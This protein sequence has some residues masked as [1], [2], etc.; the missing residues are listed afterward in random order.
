MLAR[1]MVYCMSNF[2]IGKSS[3]KGEITFPTG[4]TSDYTRAKTKYRDMQEK[5]SQS[6]FVNSPVAL[7]QE[8]TMLTELLAL[9][10]KELLHTEIKW[11]EPRLAE[12]KTQLTSTKIDFIANAY[13]MPI[14]KKGD[15]TASIQSAQTPEKNLLDLLETCKTQDGL[16]DPNA[17]KLL[18]ALKGK[19][20]N[21]AHISKVLEMSRGDD[22]LVY[23]QMANAVEIMADSGMKPSRIVEQLSEISAYEYDAGEVVVDFDKLDEAVT[24]MK[25]GVDDVDAF[26]FA[27]YLK[28]DFADKDTVR[29]SFLNLNKKDIEYKHSIGILN[30]LSVRDVDT[31]KININKDAVNAVALLKHSMASSR[32]NETKERRNPIALLGVQTFSMGNEHSFVMKDGKVISRMSLSEESPEDLK[33]KY[34]AL[35]VSIE[36]D[37]CLE[38]A[39]KYKDENGQIDRKYL[40]VA[41]FLRQQ[42][43]MVYNALFKQLD[44]AIKEDG[45]INE[46][47]LNAVK[48]LRTA[49]ALCDDVD[50]LLDTCRKDEQGNYNKDDIKDVCDLT[51]YIIGGKEVCSLAP[52]IRGNED[53]RDIVFTCA[54]CFVSPKKILDVI[55]MLKT[56]EGQYGENEVEM[57]GNLAEVFFSDTTNYGDESNFL[58]IA[59]EIMT[60]SRGKDGKITDDAGGICAIMKHANEPIES[61][62]MA[63]M[64]CRNSENLVDEKLAQILWDMYV[65][66]SNL[67]EVI[68]MINVCKPSFDTIDYA[69]ADM[70]ISLLAAKFPKEQIASLVKH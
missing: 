26:N 44:A 42:A 60:I 64:V 2:S 69:K 38:F 10:K 14:V 50:S 3:Q 57:F 37:M 54:E 18:L 51:S 36:D 48:E 41:H 53:V 62:K 55:P 34:D 46:D 11:I 45:T 56:P 32:D 61:I 29:T 59:N 6:D 63:L 27:Q 16:L 21:L 4:R 17:E 25:R 47:R 31:G 33:K 23:P 67:P 20:D 13:Y 30:T 24:L 8:M 68:D 65:Q 22:G 15:S 49:G 70:I 66:G 28:A 7:E 35:V 58:K 40:R 52:E 5:I 19:D 12:V 39:K 1:T 9:A 43:G